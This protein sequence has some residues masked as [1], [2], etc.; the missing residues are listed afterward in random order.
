M[1]V[2]LRRCVHIYDKYIILRKCVIWQIYYTQ[3]V[4]TYDRYIILRRCVHMYCNV[5]IPQKVCACDKYIILRRCGQANSS[6]TLFR[7]SSQ[8]K[9]SC[10]M[11]SCS[12][13]LEP[14]LNV[15]AACIPCGHTFCYACITQWTRSPPRFGVSLCPQC[16]APV[17]EVQKLFISD[18]PGESVLIS[19]GQ[20]S[21]Q[22]LHLWLAMWVSLD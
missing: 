4:C 10:S 14:E 6:F 7:A 22:S 19:L 9:I 13:C 20:R 11:S 1:T 5:Q 8:E 15:P 18:W 12:I 16:R 17:R 21:I 3:K 2:I